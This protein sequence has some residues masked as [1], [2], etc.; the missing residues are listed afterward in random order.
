MTFKLIIKEEAQLEIIEA[1]LYYEEKK[2]GLGG[3]FLDH[4]D[5]Y[6]KWI[7]N[8]PFHFSEKRKPFR[9]AVIKRFPYLII[10]EVLE[11]EVIV[12]SVFNTWQ[13]PK[14]KFPR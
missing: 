2:V 7:K 8:Y 11:N 4:L 6:F 9:E 3:S 12:Y 14:S 5:S 1:F 10:Y 13:N